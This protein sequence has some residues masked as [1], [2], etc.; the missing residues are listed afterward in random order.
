VRGDGY[1]SVRWNGTGRT[2]AAT[3]A[4][5]ILAIAVVIIEHKNWLAGY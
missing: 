5:A 4:C 1:L 3:Y 2:K